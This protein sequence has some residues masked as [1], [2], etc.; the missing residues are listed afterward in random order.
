MNEP[1]PEADDL[2]A[3]RRLGESYAT[4]VGASDWELDVSAGEPG[5]SVTGALPEPETPVANA[6][7]SP[8]TPPLAEAVNEPTVPP[9]PIQILEA[10]LF[11]GGPPLTAEDAADAI[12]GL[13]PEQ[14]RECIDALNRVY[15]AQNR[16]YAV[17]H[18]PTGYVLRVSRKYAAVRERLVGGPREARLNQPALDVLALIAYR[19]PTTKEEVDGTRG[20]D[21]GGVLRQL[22]R[23]GLIASAPGETGETLY[24]TTPRFLEVFRMRQLDELPTVGEPK[25]VSF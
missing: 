17:V 19:Q 10:L 11:V 13:G 22:A 21:S 24:R 18:G 8:K 7:G 23:L 12:R 16:P 25:R 15:R 3:A 20:V 4:L 6:P 2:A 5:A 1:A 9:G 14:F